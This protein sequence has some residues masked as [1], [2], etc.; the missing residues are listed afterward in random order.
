MYNFFQHFKTQDT[1]MLLRKIW[2][3]LYISSCHIQYCS[4]GWVVV[5]SCREEEDSTAFCEEPMTS[6]HTQHGT[7]TR[8]GY[9]NAGAVVEELERTGDKP[10]Y[11][12][13]R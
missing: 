12:E 10:A 2:L 13:R 7:S 4:A 1:S 6:G 3:Y 9:L 11:K 5:C 8:L